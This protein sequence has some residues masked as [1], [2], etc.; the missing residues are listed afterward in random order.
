MGHGGPV[1][2][3]RRTRGGEGEDTSLCYLSNQTGEHKDAREK[4]SH[5]KGNLKDG[6]GFVKTPDVDETADGKVVTTQVPVER[7]WTLSGCVRVCVCCGWEG[8]SQESRAFLYP[9]YRLL[10][11]L[12]VER[13]TQKRLQQKD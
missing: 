10:L 11:R 4:V 6:V 2:C 5:L 1:S 12:C 13:K 8:D 3:Y 9:H 7:A